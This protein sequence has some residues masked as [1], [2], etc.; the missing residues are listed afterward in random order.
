MAAQ[1]IRDIC[2]II[3]YP[4]FPRHHDHVLRFWTVQQ[5]QVWRQLATDA[6]GHATNVTHCR[7][8]RFGHLL[9]CAA[10]FALGQ[11]RLRHRAQHIL[12]LRKDW[13]HAT[14]VEPR[15]RQQSRFR[16]C[17][18]QQPNAATLWHTKLRRNAHHWIILSRQHGAEKRKAKILF[19]KVLTNKKSTNHTDLQ[20]VGTFCLDYLPTTVSMP[21][22]SARRYVRAYS[23]THR[24]MS[25]EPVL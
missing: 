9:V 25:A 1:P 5:R 18:H 11:K 4:V 3:L 10:P 6:I 14:I 2:C 7:H 23:R 16:Q 8:A 20:L 15:Q 19:P 17:G 21:S 24:R 22:S 13:K 12:S